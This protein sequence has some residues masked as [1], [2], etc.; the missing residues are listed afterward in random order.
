V[1]H[2]RDS[3]LRYLPRALELAR[4]SLER[5]PELEKL[6]RNLGELVPELGPQD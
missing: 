4:R 2:Q 3:Y 6:Q 5:C 1:L